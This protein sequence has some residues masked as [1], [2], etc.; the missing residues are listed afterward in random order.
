[1]LTPPT[2]VAV[3][4]GDEVLVTVYGGGVMK[5]PVVTGN[6][7]WGDSIQTQVDSAETLAQ[8][9]EAVA[10]ATGQHFWEGDDGAH[11]TQVTR[12]EWE[13]VTP[14]GTG[15]GPNSLW[16]SLGMLFCDG[17]NNLLSLVVGTAHTETFTIESYVYDPNYS[18][19]ATHTIGVEH[20]AIQSVTFDGS[21]FP[22]FSATTRRG[23]VYKKSTNL[24]SLRFYQSDSA[25]GKQV[26]V[27]YRTFASMVIYDGTGNDAENIAA[28]FSADDIMLGGNIDGDVDD[29]KASIRFF[30][31][32]VDTETTYIDASGGIGTS[33]ITGDPCYLNREI[34]LGN[35]VTDSR[36]YDDS[37]R[38]ANGFVSFAQSISDSYNT[39]GETTSSYVNS[40][41]SMYSGTNDVANYAAITATSV[42]NL[43]DSST[44][45]TETY[46]EVSARA[47]RLRLEDTSGDAIIPMP[48]AIVGLLQ[49]SATFTGTNTTA[50][51]SS[52][53]W[54][55]TY[56][57]AM[58]GGTINC[59]DY[60]TSSNGVITVL[61]KCLLEFSGVM[62]WTDTIAGMRG[63]GLFVGST[64]VGSG[65]EHS[66]FTSFPSGGSSRRSVVFPPK[67]IPLT[68]GTKIAIGRYQQQ[69]AVYQ[70][71]TNFS[72][73]TIKVI[74]DRSS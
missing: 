41:V 31:G 37:G 62:N 5:A 42:D 24:L 60:F 26:T 3:D 4:E 44:S 48:Q 58:V 43:L 7:G 1:M 12:T 18:Y 21:E 38:R 55:L 17:L 13:S 14:H 70:N 20:I 56:F 10:T 68:A 35:I 61:K 23:W 30:G 49:P 54:Q 53:G 32:S 67:C 73:L 15:K 63:F 29:D 22:K 39:G 52:A 16:N 6:P 45:D 66:S 11:V 69:N 27:R 2:T 34:G 8:Q 33:S 28:S 9:A 50:T 59:S 19:M 36:L 64:T 47:D 40:Y 74:E 65:T 57:N 46:T 71:G 51:A 72:W 25:L